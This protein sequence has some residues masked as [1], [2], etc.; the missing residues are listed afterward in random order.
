LPR[1]GVHPII[2]TMCNEASRRVSVD[3]IHDAFR[4]FR[5]PLL[6]PEGL[7]NLAALDS[8]RIT[9]PTVI[10]RA[11]ATDANA[12]E[13]VQRRWSWP[14]PSGKPVYNYRGEGRSFHNSPTGGR[15]LIPLDGFYE[16]TEPGT[17]A[18]DAP[19]PKRQKKDKWL[20]TLAPGGIMGSD[21]FCVAGV[22]RAD[23]KV[24]EAFTMLTCEPGPD[25]APYH[26]RQ[27][28]LMPRAH[29]ADWLYGTVPA[30]ELIHP[31][32][33]GTLSVAPAR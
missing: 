32:P 20:F 18:D 24:G 30:P 4:E 2:W 26:H 29:W 3:Q 23:A 22:W 8:I 15:C 1:A 17:P 13:L 5:I 25:I 28:V 10:V 14:G 16:F 9:D 12:T 31:T 11:A 21:F 6:F 27:I 19:K 7:P 33:A